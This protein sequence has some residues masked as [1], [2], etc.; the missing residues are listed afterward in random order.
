MAYK[1]P[2]HQREYQRKWKQRRRAAWF[3][4]KRCAKCGGKRRLQL[5]HRD[6]KKK[7]DH[8]IWSWSEKRRLGELVKCQ[9]LCVPC[10]TR[11]G[12]A[13]GERRGPRHGAASMYDRGCRCNQCY[14]WKSALNAQR[15]LRGYR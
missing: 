2:A 11:K 12:I 9:V 15:K 14:R 3:R 5:D 10:H 1:D 4:G 13:A 6:A 7:A 8:K